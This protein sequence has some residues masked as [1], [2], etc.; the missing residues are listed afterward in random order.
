MIYLS[1][2]SIFGVLYVYMLEHCDS[3]FIYIVKI[4]KDILTILKK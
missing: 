4:M 3:I 1:W 2:V